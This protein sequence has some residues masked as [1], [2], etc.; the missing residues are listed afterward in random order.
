MDELYTEYTQVRFLDISKEQFI[1]IA[2][3]LPSCLIVMSNGLL[4]K[5]EWVTL[6]RL[7]KILG[8]EFATEDLGQEEK[9]ENL[10]LI[11]Q[12]EMKYLIKN[13]KQWENKFLD[14]LCEYLQHN[15]SSRAFVAETM[16]LFTAP[17][18][19]P[20][21]VEVDTCSRIRQILGV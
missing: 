2:H 1:Y 17:D 20:E 3:L 16:D 8:D 21:Q 19:N 11:Y 10:M 12:G 13:K 6:K 4:E 5:E 7:T 18:Q 15:E 14:A 9:E